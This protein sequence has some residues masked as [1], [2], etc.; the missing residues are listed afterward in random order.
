M[1]DIHDGGFGR[2]NWDD[3]SYDYIRFSDQRIL[4]ET[5]IDVI[6]RFLKPNA[7][8]CIWG[9]DSS[10]DLELT[11]LLEAADFEQ[12][13]WDGVAKGFCFLFQAKRK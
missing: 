4:L 9:S 6:K 2:E 13:H 1:R 12:L 11:K 5:S 10:N 3:R 7:I 8:L